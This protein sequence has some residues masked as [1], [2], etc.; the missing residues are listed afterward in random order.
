MRGGL[1]LLEE[2]F[3]AQK[4]MENVLQLIKE[5]CLS[6]IDHFGNYFGTE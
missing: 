2:I 4:C 6:K 1:L 5:E 3:D